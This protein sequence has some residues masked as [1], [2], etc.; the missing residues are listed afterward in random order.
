LKQ[1]YNGEDF[2]AV[3]RERGP[4]VQTKTVAEELGCSHVTAR[5]WLDRLVD[6]GAVEHE[7]V[8]GAYLWSATDGED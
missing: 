2:L 7:K 1:E 3:V 6:D 4:R 5:K 8:R